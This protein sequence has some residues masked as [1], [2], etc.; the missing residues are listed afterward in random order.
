MKKLLIFLA[1][2]VLL[3]FSSGCVF[4]NLT[5]CNNTTDQLENVR[6]NGYDFGD[7]SIEQ[8][9]SRSVIAGRAYIYLSISGNDYR[10]I[11][12][13][14]VIPGQD[15]TI[16]LNDYTIVEGPLSLAAKGLSIMQIGDII[17][18][19]GVSDSE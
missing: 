6:W 10:T 19:A 4:A 11:E 17:G 12:K 18:E 3:T 8:S 13:I 7:L 14:S 9:G 16:I 15:K 2:I 5:I 1:L